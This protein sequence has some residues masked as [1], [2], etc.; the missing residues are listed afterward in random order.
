MTR[1]NDL[2]R[3]SSSSELVEG[4]RRATDDYAINSRNVTPAAASR[5]A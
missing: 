2:A 1:V 5:C 4:M 3:M